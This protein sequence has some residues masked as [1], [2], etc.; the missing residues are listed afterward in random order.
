LNVSLYFSTASSGWPAV[1]PQSAP[2]WRSSCDELIGSMDVHL[3]KSQGSLACDCGVVGGRRPS[4]W[5]IA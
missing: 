5:Q 1:H 2:T 3:G 4:M